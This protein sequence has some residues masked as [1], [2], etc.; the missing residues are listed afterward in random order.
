MTDAEQHIKHEVAVGG[1]SNAVFNGLI[2]WLLMRGGADLTWGGPHSFAGDIVA[3]AFILPFIVALIVIPLQ[4]KKLGKGTVAPIRL[5]DRNLMQVIADRIPESTFKAALCFGGL[6][7]LVYA[8]LLL[9]GIYATGIE[10]FTPN[11]YSVFK[12]IWAGALAGILVIPMVLVA[13]R[14]PQSNA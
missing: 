2:A 4:R 9:L 10:V 14:G 6:G 7:A 3:T 13:L 12:G 8:P 5:A 1:I 11:Q